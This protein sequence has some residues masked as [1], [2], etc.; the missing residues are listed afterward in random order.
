MTEVMPSAILPSMNSSL[1]TA[2]AEQRLSAEELARCGEI[3]AAEH[4]IPGPPGTPAVSLLV[5]RPSAA[6]GAFTSRTVAE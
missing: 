6:T 1:R 4:R 5:C 3:G 2:V